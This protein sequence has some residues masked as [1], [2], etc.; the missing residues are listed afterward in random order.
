M[1]SPRRAIIL[2]LRI[3]FGL[4]ALSESGA[5]PPDLL[6]LPRPLGVTPKGTAEDVIEEFENLE[7]DRRHEHERSLKLSLLRLE[8]VDSEKATLGALDG[9]QSPSLGRNKLRR[10]MD[11]GIRQE[12][13]MPAHLVRGRR[14]YDSASSLPFGATAFISVRPSL[15]SPLLVE[16]SFVVRWISLDGRGQ[17]RGLDR[18]ARDRKRVAW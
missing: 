3:G 5:E 6:A 13:Q 11:T 7:M 15:E 8:V 18:A 17:A 10:H 14:I 1:P 9:L 12:S 16:P 4:E 2:L